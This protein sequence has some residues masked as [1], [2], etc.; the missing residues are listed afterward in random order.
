MNRLA[1]YILLIFAYLTASKSF[2]PDN[3]S[4]EFIQTSH[5]LLKLPLGQPSSVVI[6]DA[7]T[8]GFFFKTYYHRYKVIYGVRPSR[9]FTVRTTENFYEHG[10]KFLGLSI[11]RLSGKGK[12][13]TL[14]MP[15][16]TLFVGN[17][18]FGR[19]KYLKGQ[20]KWTFYRTY[21]TLPYEMGIQDFTYSRETYKELKEYLLNQKIYFGPNKEFGPK[22]KISKAFLHLT[23]RPKE[24]QDVQ[25]K[26][27][28]TTYLRTNYGR[29][30]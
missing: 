17:R 26:Q 29:N 28:W 12:I 22:G 25:I 6:V 8:K 2:S 18:K 27:L 1:I 16:G 4:Y 9:T 20:Y 13:S 21:R 23:R 10:Q 14:P 5:N 11:F 30:I 24:H 19:W 3:L 15:P 7:F